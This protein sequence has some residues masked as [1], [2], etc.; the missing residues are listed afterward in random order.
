MGWTI[1]KENGL[2]LPEI[3][4]HLDANKP[5][6]RSFASHAHFDHLGKHE[7]ILCT[8]ATAT[9]AQQ[10]LGGTRQWITYDFEESFEIAPGV[11][12]KL[13][14]AGHILGSAML[15]LKK[16]GVSFLYTGDFKLS[17]SFLAEPCAT[18]HADVL[19]TETTFG[20]PR[21]VFPSASDVLKD[22]VSFCR[23]TLENGDT[24]AIFTYSLG[25]CQEVLKGL[26]NSGFNIMLHPKAFEMTQICESLGATFPSYRKL[27]PSQSEGHLLIGPPPQGHSQWT[28]G[29]KNLKTAMISGWALDPS[30]PYRFRCDKAFPLSDHSDYLDLKAFVS[31]VNPQLI[32]TTHG[33]AKEF[34]NDLRLSSYEAYALGEENQLALEIPPSIEAEA[35]SIPAIAKTTPAPDAPQDSLYTL[36]QITR[37]LDQ[38]DS[39]SKKTEIIR[40]YLDSLDAENR[41]LAAL[42]LTGFT[43][44][45]TDADYK[46]LL[47][48]HGTRDNVLVHLL[49][50]ISGDSHRSLIE[51]SKYLTTLATAPSPSFQLSFLAEEFKKIHAPSSLA[52]IHILTGTRQSASVLTC[53]ENVIAQIYGLPSS[54]IHQAHLRCG[55]MGKV[56][57]AAEKGTLSDIEIAIFSPHSPM[58]VDSNRPLDFPTPYETPLWCENKFDGIRCQIH[59]S[60]EHIELFDKT[61]KTITQ[62]FPEIVDAARIIPQNFIAD[63]ELIPWQD[64][65]PLPKAELENRL[66]RHGEDFFLGEETPVMVWLFDLL[67]L[68]GKTL[69]NNNLEQRKAGFSEFTINNRIRISPVT[70]AHS[71]NEIHDA[72]RLAYELGNQG[73]IVKHPHSPYLLAETSKDWTWV[74]PAK[75]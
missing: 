70:F 43:P 60:G 14:P 46:A 68:N 25:K 71:A 10:R 5:T 61:G 31:K 58:K 35:P 12:A 7:T 8:K 69:T 34:A 26:E 50:E 62:Q 29:I 73:V 40:D 65:H 59:K 27:D 39:T 30:A 2:Y 18:P 72:A 66:N 57:T 45:K 52:L 55:D 67:W 74:A 48:T 44:R 4:W 1:E 49:T 13:Y 63:G 75:S 11:E 16:D 56:V 24:P 20:S 15:W 17:D 54:E 51:T 41:S 3:D 21:Y 23:D 36:S 22:I 32:Y 37:A 28:G 38:T 33:F 64:E 53:A 6:K 42:F 9:L 47:T 19:L